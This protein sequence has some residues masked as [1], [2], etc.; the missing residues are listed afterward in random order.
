MEDQMLI[1][2]YFK[3]DEA[4][5]RE[6]KQKYGKYCHAI[7]YNILQNQ[8]D[9]DECENDTYLEIWNSV[10]P[11]KPSVFS[12]FLATITRRLALDRFR[13]ATADKRGGGE[14]EISLYELEECI[15]SEKNIDDA[16][17]AEMLSDAI[18]VFLKKLP[19][20]ER[21]VFLRRY[22]YFESIREIANKFGFREGK[23]KMMLKRTREKLSDH[24]KKEGFLI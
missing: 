9:A 5:I 2:L 23:I 7:A 16:L 3:R 4:A 11:H 13:K 14:T 15:P 6:T 20:T 19:E 21:T 1:A 22:F 17:S 18:S 10:P 12:A 8:E 24:L